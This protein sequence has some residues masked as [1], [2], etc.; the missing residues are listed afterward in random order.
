MA[1]PN[2][3]NVL[4]T[5]NHLSPKEIAKQ[6]VALTLLLST[7]ACSRIGGSSGLECFYIP[8]LVYFGLLWLPGIIINIYEHFNPPPPRPPEPPSNLPPGPY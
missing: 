1:C 2:N 8:V 3:L 4:K 5:I 7:I 6:T